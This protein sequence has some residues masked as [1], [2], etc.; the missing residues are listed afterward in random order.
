MRSHRK[1]FCRS[2]TLDGSPKFDYLAPFTFSLA[3]VITTVVAQVGEQSTSSL[4]L[5]AI[6]KLG[7]E[8]DFKNTSYT[9]QSGF[10]SST[11]GFSFIDC[12]SIFKQLSISR[13]DL[14]FVE[15]LPN[16]EIPS[17][18]V[19]CPIYLDRLYG[20]QITNLK[21]QKKLPLDLG[22]SKAHK[23][24]SFSIGINQIVP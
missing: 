8:F 9:V 14:E 10:D 5:D 15:D 11:T 7:M 12:D 16:I 19:N 24:L 6:L 1:F 17:C 18:E 23:V 22:T 3:G 4:G 21:K 20:L 2:T 13:A